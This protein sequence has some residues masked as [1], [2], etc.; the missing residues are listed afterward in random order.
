MP[1]EIFELLEN[2][3]SYKKKIK[4]LTEKYKYV[5]FYGCG[6][7]YDNIVDKWLEHMDRPI[8]YCCDSDPKKW[9]KYFNGVVCLSPEELKNIKSDCVVFVTISFFS[10][11][12]NY[13]RSAGF[14]SINLIYKYD[15]VASAFLDE[16]DNEIVGNQLKSARRLFSDARS[17]QVFDTIVKRAIGG[18]EDINLMPSICEPNQYF[19]PNLMPLSDDECYVDIGAYDGDTLRH[20]TSASQGKFEK[21]HAFEIDPDNY[22]Q[23]A[24]SASDLPNS[25]RIHTHNLGIWDTECDINFSEGKSDTTIGYG[26]KI[27][28]VVPLDSILAGQKVTLI[29]MDIEGAELHALSG[30]QNTIRKQNPKLA[31]CVYHHISHLWKIPLYIRELLPDH[32]LYLRHHTNLEYETVCYAIPPEHKQ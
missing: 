32:K 25:D 5:V 19:V 14:P 27:A 24:K 22:R 15:L 26:K 30:A 17:H 21:I 1:D 13:L 12:F 6:T 29:K 10:P 20:F 9:G 8:D 18:G 23:L 3:K 11:I 7:I 2:R 16:H 28:H 4:G 31:I